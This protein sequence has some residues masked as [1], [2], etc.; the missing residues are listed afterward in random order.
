MGVG[1]QARSD[2]KKTTTKHAIKKAQ[3]AQRFIPV[4]ATK[5]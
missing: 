1:Q 4:K 3:H 5:Y 2:S